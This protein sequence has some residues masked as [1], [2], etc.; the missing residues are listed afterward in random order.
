M[1]MTRDKE[2]WK[3]KTKSEFPQGRQ[4]GTAGRQK[5]GRGRQKS[6]RVRR[7]GIAQARNQLRDQHREEGSVPS[8]GCEQC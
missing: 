1:N 5:S 2:E 3:R 8:Q 6:G 7:V 4:A